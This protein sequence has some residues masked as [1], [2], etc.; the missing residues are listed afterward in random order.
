MGTPR[1][2]N[3]VWRG[4]T[5]ASSTLDAP[6]PSKPP[7]APARLRR[8]RPDRQG[9]PHDHQTCRPFQGPQTRAT[10]GEG[11]WQ[12]HRPTRPPGR[13]APMP[14]PT[15]SPTGN[16]EPQ[17]RLVGGVTDQAA[18]IRNASSGARHGRGKIVLRRQMRDSCLP[19]DLRQTS[20]PANHR[21]GR[22][23]GVWRHDERWTSPATANEPPRSVALGEFP[24]G[25]H[26]LGKA[27][28]SGPG[29]TMVSDPRH[30][31]VR[32]FGEGMG[33]R[34]SPARP[35]AGRC[36]PGRSDRCGCPTRPA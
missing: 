9:R 5:S 31:T 20:A 16:L 8:R 29:Q 26:L 17:D 33:P 7:T 12:R 10:P 1:R 11:G 25:A 21:D 36:G 28:V 30:P 22:M 14:R 2:H 15:T 27:G 4:S 23:D 18:L 3:S 13:M 35:T 34:P 24:R 19:S 6:S 32:C